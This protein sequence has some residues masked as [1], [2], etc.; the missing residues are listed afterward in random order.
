MISSEWRSQ[1]FQQKKNGDPNS[2]PMAQN[3]HQNE[4]FRNFL[5]FRSYT[6]LEI[7]YIDSFQDCL[8]SGRDETNE[9]K[10]GD[11]IWVKQAKIEPQIILFDT[12]KFRSLV[13][14]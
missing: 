10:L 11:Q 7:T 8:T 1:I 3:Q 4:V 13:F 12:F 5:K 2:G 6:F 14:L 9:K